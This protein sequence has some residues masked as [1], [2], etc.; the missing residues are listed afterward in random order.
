MFEIIQE[1][2]GEFKK[3]KIIN[4]RTNEFISI[5]PKFGANLNQI[6]LRKNMTTYSIISGSKNYKEMI[7]N[8][9]FKS[10]KLIPFPNRINNGKYS[11][12]NK[13]YQLQIN[14]IKQNQSIHGLLY[15]KEFEISKTKISENMASLE[16]EYYYNKEDAG[17]PFCFKTLIKH[18]LI[19][20]KGYKCTTTIKN[21]DT[22]RIPIGDGWH[23]YLKTNEK[24]NNILL[25]IPSTKMIQTDE[26]MIP[27]GHTKLF[28]KFLNPSK[29]REEKLDIGFA[30]EK[31]EGIAITELYDPQQDLRIVLWQ[32]TGKRKYNY[33]QI[34]THPSRM[35]IAIE[36]MT[37]NIDAFNNKEG[38]ITLKSDESFKACYGIRLK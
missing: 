7:K 36:P 16:F 1:S 32:E 30:L 14:S 8:K 10:A 31:K 24:I 20:N 4:N 26:K 2:F 27:T 25:K 21:M 33:L 37:C 6:I 3:I 34:F 22:K 12:D 18:A 17:F 11:W 29:I 38:L 13:S 9:W 5:I 15:N 28:Q 35:S 23:P 19:D